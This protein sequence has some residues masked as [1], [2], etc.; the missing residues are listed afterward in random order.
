MGALLSAPTIIT[1]NTPTTLA[2][3]TILWATGSAINSSTGLM[4]DSANFQL[5]VS[6]TYSN[7]SNYRRLSLTS[8]SSFATI[9]ADSLGTGGANYSLRL[10]P[11]GTGA[12]FVSKTGATDGL[13]LTSDNQG[14][15]NP[16]YLVF[17][18]STNATSY[19]QRVR[20][21]GSIAA[22]LDYSAFVVT[23]SNA[24]EFLIAGDG[25]AAEFQHGQYNRT[26]NNVLSVMGN[27]YTRGDLVVGQDTSAASLAV[28]GIIR[29]GAKLMAVTDIAGSSLTIQAGAGTGAAATGQILLQTPTVGASGTTQQTQ[30]TRLAIGTTSVDASVPIRL[31][32]LTTTQI[33]A[34][35][36]PQQGWMVFNTTLNLPCFYDGTA[37]QRVTASAM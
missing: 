10:E 34:L 14:T 6:N 22:G 31:N 27:I 8:T 7:N 19:T 9:K 29:S 16:P 11:S 13:V 35:A 24:T 12:V 25:L 1:S 3:S 4:F 26:T 36:S 15:V 30:A 32:R 33:N 5:G 37:W 2:A 28:G 21:Q 23:T 18:R 20:L 17:A